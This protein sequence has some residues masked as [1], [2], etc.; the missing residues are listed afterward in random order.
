MQLIDNWQD[1]RDKAWSVRWMA[2]AAIFASIEAAIP[3]LGDLLPFPSEL[4]AALTATATGLALLTRFIAQ[5]G[6]SLPTQEAA[7]VQSE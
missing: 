7:N 1:V 3:F 4:L 2:L 5:K 6:L